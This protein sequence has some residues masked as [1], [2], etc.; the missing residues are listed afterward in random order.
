MSERIKLRDRLLYP[1]A[2]DAKDVLK[3]VPPSLLLLVASVVRP[4]SHN[5]G[6]VISELTK[7]QAESLDNFYQK[8]RIMAV[9]GIIGSLGLFVAL[10][11]KE[12]QNRVH[13]GEHLTVSK[14]ALHP[15]SFGVKLFPELED[16]Q[17]VG[18]IHFKGKWKLRYSPQE[19]AHSV[20]RKLFS[21]L[22]ELSLAAESNDP[23]LADFNYFL[24]LSSM[25]TPLLEKF[26][27]KVIP[28]REEIGLPPL[29]Q[30][31]QRKL[32]LEMRPVMAALI[33]KAE[34]IEHKDILHQ[35]SR[36]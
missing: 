18:E 21:D 23:A 1:S 34:L 32:S 36:R 10:S 28:Y 9:P 30:N 7:G 22:Y 15:K 24:G 27:F 19:S 5:K 29:G 3:F 14:V 20:M 35:A 33:S 6:E 25:V 12:L 17:F 11:Y 2:Q 8:A 31:K 26:G 16:E 4:F 13:F